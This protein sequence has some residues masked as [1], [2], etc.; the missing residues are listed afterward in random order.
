MEFVGKLIAAFLILC[1]TDVVRAGQGLYD[2]TTPQKSWES[3]IEALKSGD[4]REVK[5]VATLNGFG[6]LAKL[7][8]QQSPSERLPEIGKAW[9]RME[10]RW[11]EQA[12][13]NARALLG[14]KIKE[15]G[16]EFV[17]TKQGWKLDRWSPGE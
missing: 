1:A 11:Q 9:E 3:V 10:I 8:G 7:I 17:R 15:Q 2:L 14:P 12:P 4:I 13:K 5:S 6:S 16:L